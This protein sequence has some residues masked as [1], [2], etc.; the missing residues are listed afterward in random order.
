M[1]LFY[2]GVFFVK[3]LDNQRSN[4]FER[5]FVDRVFFVIIK[6]NIT[7]TE[8]QHSNSSICAS[9]KKRWRVLQFLKPISFKNNL[10]P[11]IDPK[12]CTHFSPHIFCCFENS[13]FTFWA[14]R[15][16]I[17]IFNRVTQLHTMCIEL[18]IAY[19]GSGFME[20]YPDIHF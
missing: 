10:K 16:H 4:D 2:L 15:I 18:E 7:Y 6:V 1:H 14:L 19:F 9:N 3:H 17:G 13:I 8:V 5:T 12:I 11:P 20:K